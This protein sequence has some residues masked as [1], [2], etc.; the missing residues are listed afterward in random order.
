MWSGSRGARTALYNARRSV[1]LA[2]C[3]CGF[4]VY[5]PAA[6]ATTPPDGV[7]LMTPAA[8]IPE[9]Y[10]SPSYEG[11]SADGSTIFFVSG[12][13][14]TGQPTEGSALFE[15]VNGSIHMIHGATQGGDSEP[16]YLGSSRDGSRV[17]FTL[18]EPAG[19]DSYTRGLYV[20]SAGTVT[21]IAPGEASPAFECTSPD[22][23]RAVFLAYR[24]LTSSEPNNK[25]DATGNLYEWDEGTLKLMTADPEGETPLDKFVYGSANECRDFF[26]ASSEDMHPAGG[27]AEAG[28]TNLYELTPGGISLIDSAPGSS[29][30]L[31]PTFV[32]SSADGSHSFFTTRYAGN[33]YSTESDLFEDFSGTNRYLAQPPLGG[34]PPHDAVYRGSSADG[35]DVFFETAQPLLPEDTNGVDDVYEHTPSGDVLISTGALLPAD[36]K[37]AHFI[38]ASA[39]G[40][41]VVFGVETADGPVSTGTY[42]LFIRSPAGLEEI[43]ALPADPTV[44]DVIELRVVRVGSDGTRVIFETPA[45]LL[46]EDTSKRSVAYVFEDGTL[47]L[48]A[49]GQNS[50][51]AGEPGENRG[52]T[53]WILGTTEDGRTI[54]LG[55]SQRLTGEDTNDDWHIWRITRDHAAASPAVS[56]EQPAESAHYAYGAVVP[57]SYSCTDY[58]GWGIASCQ[59]SIDNGAGLETRAP[60]THSFTVTGADRTGRRTSRSVHYIVEAPGSGSIPPPPRLPLFSPPQSAT[61]PASSAAGGGAPGAFQPD[62]AFQKL[63]NGL[64]GENLQVAA[65]SGHLT[66]LVLLPASQHLN[67]RIAAGKT[68]LAYGS[69]AGGAG[70]RLLL[71]MTTAGRRRLRGRRISVEVTATYA[72]PAQVPVTLHRTLVLRAG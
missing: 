70:R 54:F 69:G 58:S 14:L 49:P 25:E 66:L 62:A 16:H 18:S 42:R 68:L 36:R 26:F 5:L 10:S 45:Q 56:I 24:P 39:D 43:P 64:R 4:L 53:G 44:Y 23:S 32:G 47:T 6:K 33:P 60:G 8:P 30:L 20:W 72:G 9:R 29:Y 28:N 17:F 59:G 67:V 51:D 19:F 2:L 3:A 63:L 1:L 11:E 31:Q 55:T 65:R 40:S 57:A 48:A 35:R 7:K 12:Q 37:G 21:Q 22:G 71:H 27:G 13:E 34:E 50:P 46:P 15:S 52:G 61:N 41:T 38:G